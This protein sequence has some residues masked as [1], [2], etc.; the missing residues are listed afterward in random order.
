[1]LNHISTIWEYR[2]FLRFHKSHL[3]VSQLKLLKSKYRPALSKLRKLDISLASDI[4]FPLYSLTGRPAIDPAVLVRSF[5]L[6]NHLKYSSIKLWCDDLANDS[7]LQ[8]LI[9]SFDPPNSS[10]HYDFIIRLTGFDPHLSDLAPQSFITKKKFKNKPAKGEKL[11]NFTKDD[12]ASI[13]DK[14]RNGAEFDRDRLLFTMQSLFN[15]IVVIPSLDMG[16][17]EPANSTLSGD[18]S[19]L[20]VHASCHGHKVQDAPDSDNN[21][22]F[23]APDADIGWDSDLAQYFFGFTFYNISF[24]NPSLHIDLP[25]FISLEKASRHDALTCVSA[26]AQ[27]LDI[28]PDLKPK[29]MCLDSASDSNSIYQFFQEKNI[30]PLI[31]HNKRR[32]SIESKTGESINSDG[33][34]VCSCGHT[35]TYDGYDYTR[36]RKKYRC[37]L[38][39][40]LID[41]CPFAQTCS[42]SDYGRVVYVKDKDNEPRFKGPVSYGS[43]K[44]KSIYKDRTCTERINNA[45]LNTYGLHKMHLR[46]GAK[47]GFFSIIAGINLHL[48][49]WLKAEV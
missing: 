17:I 11:I 4:L 5:V 29:Y 46:N 31:D 26:T 39:S 28:N 35:M 24:H 40:G 12:T 10:S 41:S 21:Y 43:P 6:M 19:C 13:C 15:A 49:A 38:K 3:D 16:L 27:M 22:R 42:T 37:P 48:D 47:N 44:W 7:L 23:S 25:V 9:G 18:G 32:K 45:V 30:I 1:M 2:D 14:Y 36:Y 34:P 20:H 8:Y 33:I